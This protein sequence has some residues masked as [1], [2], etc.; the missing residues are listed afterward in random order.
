MQSAVVMQASYYSVNPSNFNTAQKHLD[1]VA[2]N[3]SV[4]SHKAGESRHEAEW[5][6]TKQQR[7]SNP[8]YDEMLQRH[9][10]YGVTGNIALTCRQ[11]K[12]QMHSGDVYIVQDL[13]GMHT[14]LNILPQRQVRTADEII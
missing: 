13:Y 10:L 7:Q 12:I 9:I 6:R 8:H 5:N 11:Q 14:V 2:K 3:P 4:N 1:K